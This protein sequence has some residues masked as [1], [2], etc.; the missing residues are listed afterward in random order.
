MPHFI[1]DCSDNIILKISPND[2]MKTA[3]GTAEAT[4]LFA[5]GDIKVRLRPFQ[6]Y[7]L[8]DNKENFIHIFAYIMDGRSTEQKA[9]LST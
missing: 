4:G 8:E 7:K 5:P 3:P 2:I 9:N 1:I 6:Y